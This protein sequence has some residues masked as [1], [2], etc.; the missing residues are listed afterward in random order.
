MARTADRDRN[1]KTSNLLYLEQIHRDTHDEQIQS[2]Y[3]Q[4]PNLVA[5]T[6]SARI[7]EQEFILA[8]VTEAGLANSTT[9]LETRSGKMK[10]GVD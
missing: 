2:D 8:V 4:G 10:L 3:G 6:I 7:F 9:G 1:K 5:K